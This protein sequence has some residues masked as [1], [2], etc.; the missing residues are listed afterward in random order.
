VGQAQMILSLNDQIEQFK[1][2]EKEAAAKLK[3]L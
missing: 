2:E 3:K 1:H